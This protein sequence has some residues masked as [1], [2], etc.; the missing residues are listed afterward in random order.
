L[1]DN[2]VRKIQER[3]TPF[4]KTLTDLRVSRGLTQTQIAKMCGMAQSQWQLYES[5]TKVPMIKT[6]SWIMK[7]LHI[8]GDEKDRLYEAY[9][10]EGDVYED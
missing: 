1:E 7:C 2:V 3:T 5:G 9:M 6:L 4:G 8:E 10:R